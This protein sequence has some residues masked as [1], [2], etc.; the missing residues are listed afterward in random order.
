MVKKK[1]I[2]V[3]LI[4]SGRIGLT[5]EFD[6]KRLKPASH[7]GMWLKN[8]DCELV[9]ICDKNKSA[10]KKAKILKKQIKFYENYKKMVKA[11][12]PKIVSICT[13]KDTHYTITKECLKL[14]IKVI[15]LEKPLA[16]N[17]NQAKK[18]IKL[19]KK[20]NAKILVNHRRRY[21]EQVIK[22]KKKIDND[23][24][25][26]ILQVSS[27]YVY[28]IL[29]TGT[30]LIDTLRMLLKNKLGEVDKVIGVVNKLNNFKPKDDINID[31]FL[32][33]K[34]NV[35]ASI[36]S[37]DMK[38]YDNFDII[39]YGK[40]GKIEI[41]DIG[42]KILKYKIIKSPEHVGFTE[43]DRKPILL[44]NPKPRNQF[45]Y[46]AKNAVMCLK[47]KKTLPLCDENESFKDMDIINK[48][49]ISSKKNGKKI[50]I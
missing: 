32:F 15:V 42:R 1:K 44:C 23:I 30:H 7:F 22:L 34:K 36:Q 31:G 39:I 3:S 12:N 27:F 38:S 4:G 20:L 28:G 9:S 8:K 50:K 6:K 16:N 24:I 17:I 11:E 43:L 46:L 41:T 5:S 25:G 47:N 10:F 29:T 19:V 13:W 14:G 49:I 26:D 21:D 18:L 48:L 37:L 33:F 2:K 45:G 35:I 40:K